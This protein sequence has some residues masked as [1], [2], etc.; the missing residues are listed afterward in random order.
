[1]EAATSWKARG[2]AKAKSHSLPSQVKEKSNRGR[3]PSRE[4]RGQRIRPPELTAKA[5]RTMG[6]DNETSRFLQP[7]KT[8]MSIGFNDCQ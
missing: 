7:K 3:I 1:M 6:K 2:W 4:G 5:R 8:R